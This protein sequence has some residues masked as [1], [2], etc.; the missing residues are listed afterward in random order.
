MR[1]DDS[2]VYLLSSF[3]FQPNALVRPCSS[4]LAILTLEGWISFGL[5]LSRKQSSRKH[6]K[7]L[8]LC[9]IQHTLAQYLRL[10]SPISITQGPRPPGPFA[11]DQDPDTQPPFLFLGREQPVSHKSLL[12]SSLSTS[13]RYLNVEYL[14]LYHHRS[15]H[16]S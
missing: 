9:C 1:G 8:L 2:R 11:Q 10:L 16:A 14:C 7:L 13:Q 4:S 3:L 5:T 12:M 6:C 15:H